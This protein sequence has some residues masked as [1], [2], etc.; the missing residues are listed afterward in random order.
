MAGAICVAGIAAVPMGKYD[1]KVCMDTVDIRLESQPMNRT[2]ILDDEQ[3]THT[4]NIENAG[5]DCYIRAK[6]DV[7]AQSKNI[8][9]PGELILNTTDWILNEDGWAYYKPIL[10]DGE[11]IQVT[12]SVKNPQGDQWDGTGFPVDSVLT[13][14]AVQAASFTPDYTLSHPWGEVQIFETQHFR[15]ER[16]NTV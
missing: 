8:E 3:L 9:K 13:V 15:T 4:T 6:T 1:A 16:T 7:F 5:Q 10:H 14:Q 12:E 11:T 2:N